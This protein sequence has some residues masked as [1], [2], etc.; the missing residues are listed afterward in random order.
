MTP[1][2]LE[3]SPESD[4]SRNVEADV[5]LQA[6]RS[7]MDCLGSEP[8]YTYV[9]M[10]LTTGR[11]FTEWFRSVGSE[12]YLRDR[13]TYDELHQKQ[14]VDRNA[15]HGHRWVRDF[16]AARKEAGERRPVMEPSRFVLAGLD[17]AG[18]LDL[19]VDFIRRFTAEAIFIDGWQYSS[20]CS[21]E[22]AAAIEASIPVYDESGTTIELSRAIVMVE[23]AV[24]ELD[25]LQCL[26]TDR[27]KS[28][29]STLRALQPVRQEAVGVA[30]LPA[31]R[32]G[33]LIKD[34]ILDTLANSHNVAQFVSFGPEGR[35]RYSRILG[36]APNAVFD[37][38]GPAVERL[39]SRSPDGSVNV[40]SFTPSQPRSNAFVYGIQSVD[41]AVG[42]VQRL[43]GEN[44][45]TIVNETID[46]E[47]GGV[48]GV[49][50]H[51]FVEFLPGDTPR[52]VEKGDVARLPLDMGLRLLRQVYGFSPRLG[53]VANRRVEFSIHPERRGWRHEHT[54]LW[55]SEIH[56][57][58]ESNHRPSW[59]N[60][61]SK[62]VGDKAFGLLIAHLAGLPVP[63]TTVVGRGVAPF[64][65][66]TRTGTAEPWLRTAPK[67]RQ[68]G[69]LPTTR[70]WS[71]PFLLFQQIGKDQPLLASILHQEGVEAEFSGGAVL[72][73]DGSLSV[74]GTRGTGEK[75]MLGA[76]S[77]DL[78]TSVVAAVAELF[79]KARDRFGPVEIEWVYDGKKAW[80]V[81]LRV[82]QLM[83]GDDWIV[84]GAVDDWL[85]FD[86]KVGLAVL[87]DMLSTS[88]GSVGIRVMSDPVYTSH[89][90]HILQDARRPSYFAGR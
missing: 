45:I 54:I 77:E 26:S 44:L 14:V 88:P 36:E 31:D 53:D 66:G 39:L 82:G 8:D 62:L 80:V 34:Q 33:V 12:V 57:G 35:Q 28:V 71:D 7:F 69:L 65:F 73:S 46:V 70:G 6:V 9:S 27:L 50:Q 5:A 17:Q 67:V 15:E 85:D 18:Y 16:R 40:R 48:S 20:G 1:V 78:P 58:R 81:Q 90:A 56:E 75:Y 87:R 52:G 42:H 11:H 72:R 74:Q 38:L 49:A 68:P 76:A 64:S 32:S 10:P 86:P 24:R 21:T 63:H 41:E 13:R 43:G 4:R 84:E 19:W 23:G 51:D 47:D 79:G 60:P 59:P 22:M 83:A 2:S 55:E 29:L 3:K 89:I 30:R 61:F 25:D 37:G